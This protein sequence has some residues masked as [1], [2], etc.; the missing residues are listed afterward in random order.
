MF[1]EEGLEA[2]SLRQ[3]ARAAGYTTGALYSYFDS[4]EAMYGALLEESLDRLQ[5]AVQGAASRPRTP[6]RKFTAAVS[7]FFDFYAE[8]PRDLDLGFYLFRG[9]M[10]PRGLSA[11]LDEA[12]NAKLLA[13]LRPVADA[14]GT[15]GASEAAAIA[16][17]ADVFAY[18][19]GLLLLQ[20][21]GRARIFAGI[22]PR[23]LLTQHLDRLLASGF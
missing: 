23:Q 9:G 16:V 20:Q 1:E 22:T 10:R 5:E 8:N 6:P 17:M 21:T 12:L 11:E 18:T 19:T 13:A 3:I 15:M 4:K 7:A 14:A 2:A